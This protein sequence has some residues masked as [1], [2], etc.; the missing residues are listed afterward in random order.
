MDKISDWTLDLKDDDCVPFD[1]RPILAQG[2]DPLEKILQKTKELSPKDILLIVAPFDPVPLR[3]VMAGKG[4]DSFVSE[5]EEGYWKIFFKKLPKTRKMRPLP[6]LPDLPPFPSSWKDG[7]LGMDLRG[8]TP[9]NP[10]IAV[11][12]IIE[13]GEGGDGFQVRL[14]RDPVYLFPEL[15][16]RGWHADVIEEGKAGLLVDIVKDKRGEDQ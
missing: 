3:H 4:Y 9:P 6:L 8:L 2:T 13:T 1:V 7:R 10:M 5:V 11:L 12:K 16:L 15:A 14:N